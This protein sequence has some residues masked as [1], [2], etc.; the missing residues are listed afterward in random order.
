[1]VA[2][3]GEVGR[4]LRIERLKIKSTL[5]GTTVLGGGDAVLRSGFLD[6]CERVNPGLRVITQVKSAQ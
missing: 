4:T 2:L 3:L 1:M 6:V 5:E